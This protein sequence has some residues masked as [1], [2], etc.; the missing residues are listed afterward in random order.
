MHNLNKNPRFFPR[1]FG[2]IAPFATLPLLLT[3]TANV[4]A[5]DVPLLEQG[6]QIGD[7][8]PGRAIIWSRAD[9]PSR[10][11]L[12]YAFNEQFT[13]ATSIRGPYALEGTD[14][15]ARQ[16]L[17]GLP[18]GKDVYVKV[19]FEDCLLYTSPSPRDRTRSRMPSS[20]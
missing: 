14:F 10:M 18:E 13:D 1:S 19:W 17:V 8:A 5:G 9:R 20:A 16:D 6:I 4:A 12:K 11:M 2:L 7:L 3:L 15:T